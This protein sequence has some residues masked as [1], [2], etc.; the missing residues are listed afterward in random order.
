[1]PVSSATA[2]ASASPIVSGTPTTTKYAVLN[3]ALWN[4]SSLNIFV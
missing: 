1:M 2:T 3:A 4:V